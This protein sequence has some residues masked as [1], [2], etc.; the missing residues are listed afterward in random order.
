L[1]ILKKIEVWRA[2]VR[3][4]N[5]LHT[6]VRVWNRDIVPVGRE[7]WNIFHLI[8]PTNSRS[9]LRMGAEEWISPLL[10]MRF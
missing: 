6:G 2:E 1:K 7:F 9:S 4:P 10:L 3:V 5:L 8:R